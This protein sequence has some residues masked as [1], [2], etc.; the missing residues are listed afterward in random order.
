MTI[1]TVLCC[2]STA[3][4]QSVGPARTPGR[5]T[6]AQ[7]KAEAAARKAKVNHQTI[8]LPATS[9]NVS[10]AQFCIALHH[11]VAPAAVAEPGAQSA[12]Q[13]GQL[14]A[15]HKLRGLIGSI[16]LI[17]L[18]TDSI[19]VFLWDQTKV[20]KKL[21]GSYIYLNFD[22]AFSYNYFHIFF[23]SSRLHEISYER[24]LITIFVFCRPAPP[25]PPNL[26]SPPLSQA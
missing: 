2:R 20:E 9:T 4:S 24:N 26:Q 6:P 11:C 15:W 16:V 10:L 23:R 25:R 12:C 7:V 13:S 8:Y 14:S 18:F 21:E 19:K 3:S 5:K 17:F 1:V 22:Q